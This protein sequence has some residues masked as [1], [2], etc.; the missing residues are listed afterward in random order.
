MK[1]QSNPYL[2][3]LT[4]VF[5]VLIINIFMDNKYVHYFCIVLAGVSIFSKIASTFIEKIWLNLSFV[6]SL[7][8]PNILLSLLFFLVLTP[9]AWLTKVFKVKS[10]FNIENKQESFF[11]Q[12]NKSFDKDSF[13]NAW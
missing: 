4:I 5:G 13:E 9:I 12:K 11:V 8:I 7:I 6:L 3:V 2:T 10:D 1:Y